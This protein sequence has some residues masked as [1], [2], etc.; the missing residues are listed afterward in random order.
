MATYHPGPE[1]QKSSSF[2]RRVHPI[3]KKATGHG[4]DDWR[5]PNNT[6]IRA[7][8]DGVVKD[9]RF[10]YNAA[11]GTGWGNFILLEHDIDGKTVLTR[12]AHMIERS[13]LAK[14]TKVTRGQQI[15]KVGSTGGSTGPH[16]HFEVIENGQ[17]INPSGFDFPDGEAPAK[18]GGWSYPFALA[19][20]KEAPHVSAYVQAM[21]A[22]ED[23]F[24]PIGANSLWHGGI[25]F[26]DETGRALAQGP[27][28][29]AERSGVRCIADGEVVAY[30]INKTYPAVEFR[31]NASKAL[32][33][34]GFTLVRHTLVLPQSTRLKAEQADLSQASLDDQATAAQVEAATARRITE[35]DKKAKKD[36]GTAVSA[37]ETLV[38]YSLYMHLLD[39]RGY[40]ADTKI[41]PPSFWKGKRYY[42]VG[43]RAATDSQTAPPHEE[44]A[45]SDDASLQDVDPSTAG[46]D[47]LDTFRYGLE[48]APGTDPFDL[49]RLQVPEFPGEPVGSGGEAG[50]TTPADAAVPVP[51]PP[52]VLG[53]GINIRRGPRGAKLGILAA[54]TRFRVAEI[55]TEKGAQWGRIGEI[56]EGSVL[57]TVVE[58]AVDPAATQGWVFLRDME[59]VFDEPDP[60]D[61]VVVLEQP[62]AV[63]AGD[64]IGQVGEYQPFGLARASPSP[65]M[66]SMLHLEVFSGGDVPGFIGRCRAYAATLPEDERTHLV[67]EQGVTLV[68]PTQ[69]DL[70]LAVG[71]VIGPAKSSPG[72]AWIKV[73]RYQL[74]V[75]DKSTL[76]GY[77][78]KTNR[79]KDG[80]IFTGW[81]VN[82]A[83]ERTQDAGKRN[84]YTRREVH[85]PT[86]QECWVEP[87][88]VPV[89]APGSPLT[90]EV[91][92]WSAFPLQLANAKSPPSTQ[93]RVMARAEL[94]AR[95]EKLTAVDA[96]GKRWWRVEAH[97]E[98]VGW[99]R[100]KDHPKTRW[101]SPWAWPGFEFVEEGGLR[102]LDLFAWQVYQR[103]RSMMGERAD[104][105]MRADKVRNSSLHR[106]V[107]ELLDTDGDGNLTPAELKAA[108]KSP[109]LAR[110]LQHL[111]ARYESE[112]GGGMEK[113]TELDRMMLRA[114][115]AEWSGEKVRIEQL[116]WWDAAKGVKDFPAGLEVYH[117]HPIGLLS[118]FMGARKRS[119]CQ[120]TVELLDKVLGKSGPYF[121][122]G[123]KAVHQAEFARIAPNVHE[124][125]KQKFV[126]LL[127]AGLDKFGITGCYHR[128][129]FL[130]QCFH[131]SDHFRTTIEYSSGEYLD[132]G[133]HADAEKMG[134]TQVGD[135]PKY[136]GKGLIQLTWKNN[137]QRFSD[138]IG[139][140]F[141]SDPMAV[142][143]DM[144]NSVEASCWYWRF[145]GTV[146]K[147]H[148]AKGDINKLIDAEP[149]NVTLVTLAVNGGD[150]GLAGRKTLFN[151]VKKEWGLE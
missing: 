112:W 68:T 30:R 80:S 9:N 115:G 77:D 58:E 135:G 101:E 120:I 131:E 72:G 151:A 62:V 103:G 95:V 13:P 42:K 111:I 76:T 141:V 98:T 132:P 88:S 29:L 124:M 137:Y 10:Q 149:N 4:G 91:P 78:A 1:Y 147:K 107:Y 60:L 140:D 136:K 46:L 87:A 41:A 14:G 54:G 33:S 128:A 36:S 142:A 15:G 90:V 20:G 48:P 12:Y 51:A 28:Q 86:G 148:D 139:H 24:F 110:H 143:T 25:H 122:G 150:N 138:Y 89:Q 18:S 63:K 26:S 102:P 32:Y 53:K 92:A 40:R 34:T 3:T 23:G 22:A 100:E 75:V 19:D 38:Y 67:L 2:G 70:K 93:Q 43:S 145:N 74:K 11:S 114:Q 125:D 84:V 52:A 117:F 119:C 134:N 97:R 83:N 16:L 126:D 56:I 109:M 106:K 81:Y 64:V 129:H 123:P 55:K 133:R 96:E 66:R 108:Q 39:W 104:H 85:A 73:S 44:Q 35:D 57:P 8:Y 37:A 146:H 6:P 61:Q 65:G 31:K 105:K 21:A 99:V 127:N 50:D 69:A 113:W 27:L 59:T 5:A 144:K 94:D 71:E 7:A 121:D 118:N 45:H 130:A 49:S 47:S 82:A 79:Y 116:Q 17:P